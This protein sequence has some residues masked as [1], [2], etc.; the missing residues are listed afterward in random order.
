MLRDGASAIYG[1]DAIAGVINI[2]TRK[3][4][5]GLHLAARQ[6]RPTQNG[7]DEDAYSIT[8]GV[9]GAKGNITFAFDAQQRDLVYDGDRSFSAVGTSLA[10]F[11]SSYFA[12]LAT[13]DPRNPF[14]EFLSLGIF[15]D[16]RCPAALDTDPT[17]PDSALQSFP[18]GQGICRYNYTSVS[19]TE[20]SN[21]TNRVELTTCDR[22]RPW[23]PSDR[24]RTHRAACWAAGPSGS[25]PR[26]S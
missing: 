7:G 20:A 10:G 4:Y 16:P 25:P 6:G 5:E 12:Y 19:A 24:L 17:Y 8:G 2:I 23:A 14:G 1:T 15:A 22:I 13:E 26:L 3:D 9:S 18:G 11:P 21:D